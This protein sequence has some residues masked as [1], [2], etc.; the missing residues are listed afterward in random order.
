MYVRVFLYIASRAK[1]FCQL[2]SFEATCPEGSVVLMQRALYG[3]MR[4]GRCLPRDYY[5]GCAADVIAEMDAKCSG[6]QHCRVAIPEHSLLRALACPSDLV[7]YLEAE[8]TCITG[9]TSSAIYHRNIDFNVLNACR[10]VT[11]Y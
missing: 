1:D 9:K 5:V 4:L 11:G 2:E 10:L 3:R 7:S 6:R 8:Y